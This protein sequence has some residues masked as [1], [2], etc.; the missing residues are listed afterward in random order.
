MFAL[1]ASA[2]VVWN[3]AGA[4]NTWSNNSNW[5][6]AA[7]VAPFNNTVTMNGTTQTTNENDISG[8]ILSGLTFNN[9]SWNLSGQA[10]TINGTLNGS[11]GNAVTIS[12]NLTFSGSRTIQTQNTA[13]GNV[14]LSGS[15][16]A[17][18]TT[19]TKDGGG[20]NLNITGST[21]TAATVALRKGGLNLSNGVNATAATW[22]VGNDATFSGT[23]PSLNV[24]GGGT[25]LNAST[26]IEVG[27]SGNDAR[28]NVSGG[29]VT[30]PTILTGQAANATSTSGVYQ[31]GGTINVTN[32]RLA[33]NG[34][35]TV[36]VSGGTMNVANGNGASSTF[37]LTQNGA[38][39]F[40]ISGGSVVIG[41]GD[42]LKWN[43]AAGTGNGT[44]NLN[45]GTL[46]S[47][48]FSKVNTTGTSTI[49]LNGGTLRSLGSA[50]NWLDDLAN[51]SV[52]VLAGG[53]IIDSNGFTFTISEA[54]LDGGGGG[55]LTKNGLGT[56]TLAGANTFAGNTVV[57]GG[58]LTLS[59]TS[60]LRF[61][62]GASGVNNSVGGTGGVSF[63]GLFK[64]D[65]SAAASVG[66]WNVVSVS[67]LSE[68]FGSTFSVDGFTDNLDGTW[69]Q[70]D[71]TFSE[72]TGTLTAVP[73]PGTLGLALLAAASL[74]A[75]RHV[76]R[77]RTPESL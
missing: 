53:A 5:N 46:S 35:S 30:A 67:T 11:A 41:A 47:Y 69:S 71:F 6:T 55:G 14:T 58:S 9:S 33:N 48:G 64:F 51:T 63:N 26:I 12:N 77:L 15:V 72:L 20:S 2:Q 3:G 56:L 43:L 22:Q 50:T 39:I 38:S 54:L 25:Q 10:F 62:I 70:G 1:P 76:R 31:S 37:G 23:N 8:L 49:N 7:P 27:R 59:S 28:L 68:S 19:L 17:S 4:N 18:G 13:G 24:S 32:L 52:N 44:L 57:N 66:T 75:V 73:E 16:N 40:T 65:L 29:T 21:F 34:A 60:E 45:S 36:Q 61:V 42:T 74:L